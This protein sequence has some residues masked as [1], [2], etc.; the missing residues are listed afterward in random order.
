N[1]MWLR[2]RKDLFDRLYKYKIDSGLTTWEHVIDKLLS[3]TDKN[4]QGYQ[5]NEISGFSSEVE[6]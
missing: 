4:I 6:Q 1:S 3:Q 2:V 5:N